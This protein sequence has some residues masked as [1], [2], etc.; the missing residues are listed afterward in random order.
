M[1]H[2]ADEREIPGG[3]GC[4]TDGDPRRIESPV[5]WGCQ[6]DGVSE[7]HK[8][9]QRPSDERAKAFSR[10]EKR[11]SEERNNGSGPPTGAHRTDRADRDPPRRSSL[12]RATLKKWGGTRR[13][14]PEF[15]SLPQQLTPPSFHF[16]V[17][18]FSKKPQ[19]MWAKARKGR[20][21]RFSDSLSPE[22]K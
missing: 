12:R 17:F 18:F 14:P 16:F 3:W 10:M 2:I 22:Y 1:L 13:F 21:A 4:Q 8:S 15:F 7:R 19:N 5:G 20:R 6:A 11:K 9:I